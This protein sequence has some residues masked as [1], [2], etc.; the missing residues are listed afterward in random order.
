MSIDIPNLDDRTFDDLVREGLS[1]L[2]AWAPEWTDHNASDPG[3]TL[4]E[5]LAY[6]T[7][8]LLYRIGRVTPESKLQ[9]LRLLK[10]ADWQGWHDIPRGEAN[11]LR[12]VI[13]ETVRELAHM[14]CAVTPQDFERLA[15][16]AA[17]AHLGA[18]ASVRTLAVASVDLEHGGADA[19]EGTAQSHVSVVV[20]PEK[21]LA[22][23]AAT[24][25]LKT[26][27][28]KLDEHSLL[29]TR[30]HVV[31]PR[32][33]HLAIGFRLAPQPGM[34]MQELLGPL[35]E[36]LDRRF[37]SEVWPFGKA[38]HISEIVGIIDTLPGVDYVDDV[39]VLQMSAR[40]DDLLEDPASVGIQ[41]GLRSTIGKDTWLGG[42]AQLGKQRLYRN[43]AGRLASIALRP[44]E[45]V[46]VVIAKPDA[47]E[48]RP[49][50]AAA[51]PRT[52]GVT[53]SD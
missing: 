45:L 40:E 4:V 7:E 36:A 33:L 16:D 6:F 3:I 9:F 14:E 29:T 8:I 15:Q 49:E 2:P 11:E 50:L 5:L 41:I 46:R 30:V 37:G 17:R 18:E 20:A 38:L 25:L 10:G 51:R 23:A 28:E 43:D 34:P 35:Q 19:E 48:I 24:R 21:E 52:Q 53:R 26:V 44:W 47:I 42:P 27:K 39:T 31:G 1:L 22:A 13:E 12:R 32:Y